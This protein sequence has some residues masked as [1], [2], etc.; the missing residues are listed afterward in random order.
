[1]RAHLKINQPPLPSLLSSLLLFLLLLQLL[2]LFLKIA[3][4]LM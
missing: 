4:V 3:C 1:M 2:L